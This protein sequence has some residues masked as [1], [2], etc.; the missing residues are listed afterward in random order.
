VGSK[1]GKR[2]KLKNSSLLSEELKVERGAR[3]MGLVKVN[4]A[5][6]QR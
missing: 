5:E 6:V 3:L 2:S 4:T 1:I